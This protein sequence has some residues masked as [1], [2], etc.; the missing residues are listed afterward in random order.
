MSSNTPTLFSVL[1]VLRYGS[2]IV[3]MKFANSEYTTIFK[4]EWKWGTT[5]REIF[6]DATLNG[7]VILITSNYEGLVIEVVPQEDK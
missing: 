7:D 6:E 5:C 1:R 4:G 2:H 3:V